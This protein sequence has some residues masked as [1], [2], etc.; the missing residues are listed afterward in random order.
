MIAQLSCDVLIIGAGLAGLQAAMQIRRQQ[1]DAQIMLADLG[2]GASTEIMGF[3]AP[4]HPDDTADTFEQDVLRAGAGRNDRSLVHRLTHEAVMQVSE[5]EALG[6]VFD[7]CADGSYDL[8]QSVGSSYPRVIH[9][10][11]GTG[12][13]IMKRYREAVHDDPGI[14]LERMPI[15]ELLTDAGHIIGALGWWQ[16]APCA[17]KAPAVILACGGAAGLYGFSS[18]SKLLRGSGYV[19][20]ARAGATLRDMDLIQFEPT[21][22]IYPP[23]LAGFPLITTLLY[24]GAALRDRDGRSLLESFDAPPPKRVLARLV[25]QAIQAGQGTDHGGV[26]YALSGVDETRFQQKYPGYYQKL[27][28]LTASYAVLRFEVKPAAH[29]TL[30]GVIIDADGATAVPGLFAAGECVGGIHGQDRIGGNAGLEVLVFGRAAGNAAAS[31]PGVP[32]NT[33]TLQER[34]QLA[35]NAFK[36]GQGSRD[37]YLTEIG[38]VLDQAGSVLSDHEQ[39]SSGLM[40]LKR[41]SNMVQADAPTHLEDSIIVLQALQAASIL[42]QAR[43]DASAK[44]EK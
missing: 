38:T 21:V 39:V 1:A 16:D 13:E 25:A 24:E 41:L 27:R 32:I 29:T 5:L 37:F 10:G 14:C 15:A 6:L 18:W 9:Q 19:L 22:T 26:W 8:L 40:Q 7:R 33:I 4:L 12:R 44:H 11:T 23:E 35:L 36:L 28:P 42:L 2:G 43:L 31:S 3:C 17:V 30:G 20:A 34:A